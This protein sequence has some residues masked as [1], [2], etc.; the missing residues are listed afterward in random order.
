M[1]DPRLVWLLE[2]NCPYLYIQADEAALNGT[3]G[4]VC[5]FSKHACPGTDSVKSPL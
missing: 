1:H 2:L 4:I 3:S 5:P